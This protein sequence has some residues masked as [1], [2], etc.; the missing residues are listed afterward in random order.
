MPLEGGGQTAGLP[1]QACDPCTPCGGWAFALGRRLAPTRLRVRI[2]GTTIGTPPVWGQ[3]REATWRQAGLPFQAALLLS[4]TQNI[5]EALS[6]GVIP[7]LPHP[8]LL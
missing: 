2:N 3:A 8:S 7:R 5:G 6:R 1:S 4:C